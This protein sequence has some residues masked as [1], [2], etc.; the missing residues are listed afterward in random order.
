VTSPG[1]ARHR[2]LVRSSLALALLGL[3]QTSAYVL[4]FPYY[5]LTH[6][7]RNGVGLPREY[8]ASL[9]WIRE[10][11]PL[12]AIVVDPHE[13]NNREEIITLTLAERRVWLPTLYTNEFLLAPSAALD[14]RVAVWREGGE[15][16]AR[17]ADVLVTPS[18]VTSPNWRAVHRE[19]VWTVYRSTLH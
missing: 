9:D 8:V 19:G 14:Q 7:T 1:K 11:T 3:I 17:E 16:M 15:A 13:L 4:Q 2:R 6:S 5:R 12:T 10:H 18:P